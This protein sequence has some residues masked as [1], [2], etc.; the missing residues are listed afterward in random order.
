MQPKT[1]ALAQNLVITILGA[2]MFF[3][4]I[5]GMISFGLNITYLFMAVLGAGFFF[6]GLRELI[7][8]TSPSK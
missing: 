1:K 3:P 5:A 7:S 2:I 6:V 4:S 8:G